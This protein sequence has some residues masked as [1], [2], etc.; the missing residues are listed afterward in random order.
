MLCRLRVVEQ[1]IEGDELAF[2]AP[3]RLAAK[4]YDDAL[5]SLEAA[6]TCYET[7]A[8]EDDYHARLVSSAAA[9]AAAAAAG[10]GDGGGGDG[11]NRPVGLHMRA[12]GPLS[13][14]LRGEEDDGPQTAQQLLLD[15][16][17]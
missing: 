16:A 4:Q 8:A 13:A 14:L 1:V 9:A 12:D 10:D 6:K 11:S 2:E 3:A 7:A 17:A 15:A 5:R